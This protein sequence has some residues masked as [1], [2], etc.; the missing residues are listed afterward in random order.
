[1]NRCNCVRPNSF[2]F[3]F[4]LALGL[5][6]ALTSPRAA[7]AAA[8]PVLVPKWDRFE[9]TFESAVTYTNPTQQV[10]LGALLK[11][12]SG[13]THKVYCFWDGG[14]TWRLRF[15]PN[16]PGQWT[17]RTACNDVS[18]L[19][20]HEQS[21]EFTCTAP[22]QKTRFD[23]HGPVR[24]SGDLRYFQ[25]EDGTPFFWLADTGWNAA[26]LSSD[27][28]WD[29][30]LKERARQKFT[31]VQFV[32]TQF[33]A[34][35]DGDREKQLAFTGTD[36]IT[37]N[38][39]FF[40]RLD[41]KIETL[42][43]AGLLAV[44]AMLWAIQGGGNPRVNPGVSLPDDQAVLLARHMVAR[45][46]ASDVAWILAGDSHYQDERAERWKR[47]G[48]AVFG[49][50]PHA[51][52]TMHPAGMHWVWNE[53]KDEPWFDFL[54]YQSGH[55][56]DDKTLRWITEGPLNDDW[57]KLPHRPF[58]N[59]EPPYENH[60][61]YQSK[62]PH[63]P[64]NVRRAIYWSLLNAPT[65]GVTYGGHGV[66]GWD[67]GTKPPTDHPNTGV[68]LPWR[69]ALTMP[70]AE[71][72]KHLHDF[73]TSIDWWRLRP[74]SVF[75]VNQPGKETPRKFI[76]A[77]RT[78]QKDLLVVY[79]PEDRTVEIKLDA[80]PPSPQ[81]TWFNP[82][83]GEKSPAVAVVTAN[84][85]QFPTPSEGDWILYMYTQKEKEKAKEA[86]AK[87]KEGEKK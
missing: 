19:S 32:A 41:K 30:Y 14:K 52:V 9:Q 43:Q 28:E 50:I 35:P 12:P 56:D 20:L 65:A 15:A 79:V 13:Q 75:V 3:H 77:A 1:M 6:G 70:A 68:P 54:G 78:D 36:K 67:D 60:L 44:P 4:L 86:E 42:N 25:H 63:P 81:V 82:R 38:P 71:Q 66:W 74:A 2:A 51:P 73:F 64:E 16:E 85:C 22:N 23:R 58:I 47:I 34:A 55:G 87:P 39:A 33:R 31:A 84:T 57:A 61:A 11:S 7:T 29:Q 46:G 40:Q 59:L 62:K 17:W 76:A 49:E 37:I 10:M 45:W 26:L 8:K 27:E 5:A 72:M 21:G 53:F 24:V 83:T 80:L 48:R 18:N 69:K